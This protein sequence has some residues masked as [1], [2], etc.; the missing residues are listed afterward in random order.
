M[1]NSELDHLKKNHLKN[2]IKTSI[3][4]TTS[5]QDEVF[6]L[7]RDKGKRKLNLQKEIQA[8]GTELFQ[9]NEIQNDT[10]KKHP[11]KAGKM[12]EESDHPA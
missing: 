3:K 6:E 12:K 1:P 4:L 5:K 10:F 2:C 8:L 9:L 11:I 7:Y